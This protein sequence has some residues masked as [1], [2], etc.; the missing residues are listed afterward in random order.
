M[1]LKAG[2]IL[3][4]FIVLTAIINDQRKLPQKGKFRVAR[5]RAQLETEATR[6]Q[7]ERDE[8]VFELG[9]HKLVMIEGGPTEDKGWEVPP[10]K[11]PEFKKR[12]EAL[13]ESLAMAG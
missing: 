11:M 6:I 10:E 4:A 1:K 7:K 2:Q 12:W 3:D 9:E 5:C 8:I 13:P